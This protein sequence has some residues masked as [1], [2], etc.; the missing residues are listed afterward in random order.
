VA[1]SEDN[2]EDIVSGAVLKVRRILP[3][4]N[5]SSWRLVQFYSSR[6]DRERSTLDERA[7]I[8]PRPKDIGDMVR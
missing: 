4:I 6:R 8:D 5:G 2:H 1:V 7:S 3:C